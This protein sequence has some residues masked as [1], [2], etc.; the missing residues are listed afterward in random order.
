MKLRSLLA[1]GLVLAFGQ[2]AS[3]GC[4]KSADDVHAEAAPKVSSDAVRGFDNPH[5]NLP[6]AAPMGAGPGAG[7]MGGPA[8]APK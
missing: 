1:L 3:V 2:F 7:A 5:K 6:G 8:M 4:G